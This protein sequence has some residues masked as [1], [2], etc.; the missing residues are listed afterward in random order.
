MR[1]DRLGRVSRKEERLLVE[2]EEAEKEGGS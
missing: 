1:G 2:G